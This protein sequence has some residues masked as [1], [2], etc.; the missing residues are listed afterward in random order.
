MAT[1]NHNPMTHTYYYLRVKRWEWARFKSICAKKGKSMSSVLGEF[2]TAYV[3][4]N[5]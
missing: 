2:I 1:K 4:A 3:G 5:E